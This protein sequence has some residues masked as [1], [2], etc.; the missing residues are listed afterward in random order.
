[1]LLESTAEPVRVYKHLR[2]ILIVTG[3]DGNEMF[4]RYYDPRVLRVF[5]P[6]CELL[7]LKEFFGPIDAFIAEDGSGYMLEFRMDF[8]G[9]L[10][11][12]ETKLDLARYLT[13]ATTA[14]KQTG[15]PA[16]PMEP[17]KTWD[18]GY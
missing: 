7:Q 14:V 5:L 9:N 8:N 17:K 13:P 6:T 15:L 18:F 10:E 16:N 11:I 1:V 12:H 2:K 3:E 4:F